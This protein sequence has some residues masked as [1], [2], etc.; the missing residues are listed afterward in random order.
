MTQS[1]STEHADTARP[2]RYL[3]ACELLVADVCLVVVCKQPF[4]MSRW[5]AGAGAY[6]LS[7]RLNAL[8]LTIQ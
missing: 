1:A 4:E 8:Y 6:G 5:S 7:V 2:F 3:A